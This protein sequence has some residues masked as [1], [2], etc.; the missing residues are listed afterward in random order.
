MIVRLTLNSLLAITLFSGLQAPAQ[1][2]SA[3]ELATLLRSAAAAVGSARDIAKIRNIDVEANCLGPKG[4]YTTAISSFR[5]GKT[6]FEQTYSY[7]LPSATFINGDIGWVRHANAD[8]YSLASPFQRMAARSHEYQKMAFDIQN[9]FND[10]ELIGEEVF[11]GRQSVKVRAKNELGMTTN[12]YF[13]KTNGRLNGY[14]LLIPNSTETIKNTILEWKKVGRLLL[15]SVVRATDSQG[16]WTLRFHTIRLNIADERILNVPPRI[17]DMAE[18]MRM[19]EL[20]KTAH[21]TYDAELLLGDSPE[22]P[23]TLSRGNVIRNTRVEDLARFKNYFSSFNFLEWEDIVPPMIKISKDG[24]IATKIVQKRVRG[25][26]KGSNADTAIQHTV[27]AWLE[28][29]EK[30]DG[31]WRLTTIASTDKPGDQ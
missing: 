4:K 7:R 15:P 20:Q 31:R 21:L 16:E 24:T 12:I 10:L 14:V 5:V 27:F 26:R 25:T 29:L 23:V 9:F 8:E 11:D 13:D 18:I 30:I 3:N 1:A 17:A 6:R 19:H 22:P 28:V 2:Q